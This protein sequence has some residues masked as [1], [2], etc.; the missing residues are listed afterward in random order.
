MPFLSISGSDFM[1]MFVGVGPARVRDL[2]AQARAQAPSIIFIGAPCPGCIVNAG[3]W[4]FCAC[5]ENLIIA[6]IVATFSQSDGLT[7]Y[8][9]QVLCHGGVAL[10]LRGTVQDVSSCYMHSGVSHSYNDSL[11]KK[12][13]ALRAA[14]MRLTRS[15]ARAGAA[16]SPAATT[17]ARIR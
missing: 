9:V 5:G 1:E 15:G 4:P 11:C 6:R 3:Y 17:S 12:K 7:G 16:G 2:F 10:Q 13:V 14:Q 8:R